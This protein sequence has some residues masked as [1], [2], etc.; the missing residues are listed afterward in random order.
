[1]LAHPPITQGYGGASRDTEHN[2]KRWESALIFW[3]FHLYLLLTILG[4]KLHGV[5]HF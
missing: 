3:N 5:I 2:D 4:V 1:M